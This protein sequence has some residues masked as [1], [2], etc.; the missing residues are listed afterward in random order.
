MARARDRLITVTADKLVRV[1]TDHGGYTAGECLACGACGWLCEQK[2]G[3]PH[4][5]NKELN[6]LRHTPKCPVG[7]MLDKNGKW[8]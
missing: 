6:A 4:N 1:T 7:S 2:H 8:K 3:I 5:G